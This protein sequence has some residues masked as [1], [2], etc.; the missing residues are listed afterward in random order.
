MRILYRVEGSINH[1]VMSKVV[2]VLK[3]RRVLQKF[4][5]KHDMHVDI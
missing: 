1:E 2:I 3:L 4:I 5:C